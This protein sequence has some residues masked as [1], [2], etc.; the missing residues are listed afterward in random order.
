VGYS[1]GWLDDYQALFICLSKLLRSSFAM[2]AEL[3]IH[4]CGGPYNVSPLVSED[5]PNHLSSIGGQ[6]NRNE[7]ELPGITTIY[8]VFVELTI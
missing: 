3:R 7:L 6:G 4:Q 1:T 5:Q 8:E 2:T